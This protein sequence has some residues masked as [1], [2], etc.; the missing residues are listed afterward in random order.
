M[1]R[2]FNEKD[3]IVAEEDSPKSMV[4]KIQS[5]SRSSWAQSSRRPP[6]LHAANLHPLEN[7]ENKSN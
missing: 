7:G 6:A 2:N 5:K 1:K 4:S 3:R